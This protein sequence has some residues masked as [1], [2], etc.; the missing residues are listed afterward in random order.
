MCFSFVVLAWSVFW[1]S[2]SLDHLPQHEHCLRGSVHS[3]VSAHMNN[4]FLGTCPVCQV[5]CS[6]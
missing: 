5:I 6:K 1:L 2:V 4:K 3:F